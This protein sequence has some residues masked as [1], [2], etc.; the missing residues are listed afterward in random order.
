M[1][2]KSRRIRLTR[3]FE[4]VFAVRQS[5]HA[6]LFRI[7]IA[8]NNFGYTRCAVVV[9]AKV[10]KRA[11]VRNRVRRRAWSVIAEYLDTVPKGLDIVFMA[12]PDAARADFEAIKKE[13]KLNLSK[14]VI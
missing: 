11:V 7:K 13:L 5:V 9:S 4:R 6:A 3:D 2:A 1:I 8:R 10:S 14:R 12:T